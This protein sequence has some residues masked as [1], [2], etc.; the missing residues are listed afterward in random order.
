MISVQEYVNDVLAYY[1]EFSAQVQ[2][3]LLEAV[4]LSVRGGF[5]SRPD[6]ALNNIQQRTLGLIDQRINRL[7][8]DTS[9]FAL[10]AVLRDTMWE[11]QSHE[12]DAVESIEDAY[13]RYLQ[14]VLHAVVAHEIATARRSYQQFW[15][16]VEVAQFQEGIDRNAAIFRE[17]NRLIN[18]HY[19]RL[20]RKGRAWKMQRY[21]EVET[22][23]T[24]TSLFND[25]VIFL[26]QLR[27][28]TKAKIYQPEHERHSEVFNMDDYE[29][30]L[31]THFHPNSLAI[32]VP[33]IY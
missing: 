10:Q 29:S 28:E 8:N 13:R 24:L 23:N 16:R 25:I 15:L 17:R 33:V 30:M 14:Q 27:G 31:P 3:A 11:L 19:T 12:A 26:L 1:G 2:N 9:S 5:S 7:L 22:K 20:D 32:V 18:D 21:V 6:F 4:T